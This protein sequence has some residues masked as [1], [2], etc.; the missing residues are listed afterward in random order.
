MYYSTQ[1][2]GNKTYSKALLV[3]LK[4]GE[5]NKSFVRETWKEKDVQKVVGVEMK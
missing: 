4:K 1:R 5:L 2:H 3:A